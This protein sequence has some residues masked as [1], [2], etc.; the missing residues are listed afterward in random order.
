MAKVVSKVRSG[1]RPGSRIALAL[2]TPLRIEVEKMCEALDIS[3]SD[4]VRNLLEGAVSGRVKLTRSDEVNSA[5]K[6]Y[7]E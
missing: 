2:N 4:L 5:V 1:P 3:L 6:E 7:F